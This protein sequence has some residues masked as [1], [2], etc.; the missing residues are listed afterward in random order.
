M[1]NALI[2]QVFQSLQ[3]LIND[4]HNLKLIQGFALLDIIFEGAASADLEHKM[5]PLFIFKNSF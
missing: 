2:M 3:N 1:T 5:N 4:L